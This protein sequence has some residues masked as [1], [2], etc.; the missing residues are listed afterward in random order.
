M[1][2]REPQGPF[3]TSRKEPILGVDTVMCG[4]FPSAFLNLGESFG[5]YRG[6][7]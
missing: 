5:L 4:G 1:N 2:R 3:A 7:G 6:Y